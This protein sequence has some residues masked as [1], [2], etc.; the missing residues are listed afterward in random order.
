MAMHKISS[1]TMYGIKI[2]FEHQ[3]IKFNNQKDMA[4]FQE[5]T[6]ELYISAFIKKEKQWIR[7]GLCRNISY[8]TYHQNDQGTWVHDHIYVSSTKAKSDLL[9]ADLHNDQELK[10][11]RL[12]VESIG[13]KVTYSQLWLDN[14]DYLSQMLHDVEFDRLSGRANNHKFIL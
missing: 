1:T 10:K 2:T 3:W 7:T 13:W 4:N 5:S 6:G 12:Y 8:S 11:Q 14:H 9:F